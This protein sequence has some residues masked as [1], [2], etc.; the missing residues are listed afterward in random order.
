MASHWNSK[1]AGGTVSRLKTAIILLSIFWLGYAGTAN[2][3]ATTEVGSIPGA[4]DVTLSGS[5][6]YSIPIRIAPGAAGTEPKLAI[7]YDSQSMGSSMGAGWSISGLAAITRG[8]KN[9]FFDGATDGVRL[10]DTDA[11]FLHG[12]RLVAIGATGAGSTR[13]IEYRKDID[14]Q[15]EVVQIGQ[16]LAAANF[17]VRTKG[18]LTMLFGSDDNSKVK[19]RSGPTLLWA[20]SQIV[21]SVG[22]YVQFKYRGSDDGDY[23]IASVHYTG[24]GRID[25]AGKLVS[26]R[27]G[28]AAV[29]FEY[30]AAPRIT[31]S[32]V[33][34]YPVERKSRL[35][36]VRTIV[37]DNP[38]AIQ[39]GPLATPAG[40]QQV[41]RY[42]FDYVDR[43]TTAHRFVLSAVH[44]FGEDDSEITPTKFTYSEPDVGW[45]VADYNLPIGLLFASREQLA[46]AYR[47]V[48][49]SAANLQ[50]PELLFSATID[51]SLESYA[52]KNDGTTWSAA[53]GFK[54]PFP[55]TNADGADLGAVLI[56][57]NGDGR[58]DLLKSHKPRDGQTEASSYLADN[59]SWTQVDG[60]KLPFNVSIEGKRTATMLF[61]R[62]LGN[63]AGPDLIYE[64]EGQLGFLE[65]TGSGWRA[66]A[67]LAPPVP[68]SNF[69]R[70]FDI[71]CD[72]KPELIA[73][74]KDAAGNP[75]WR[76]FRASAAGWTEEVRPAYLPSRFIPASINPQ[77]I[78]ELPLRGSN[79][80]SL[81][82]S[83]GEGGGFSIALRG[84]PSGWQEVGEKKPPFNLV[85]AS[86][87]ASGA[88]AVD[89]DGDGRV[90]VIAH[91]MVPNGPAI[92]FAFRQ[93]ETAWIASSDHEPPAPID[94]AIQ[95]HAFVGDLDGDRRAEI[96]LPGGSGTAL[97]RVWK[98][99]AG[100]FQ[101]IPDYGPRLAFARLD[102]QDRGIRMLDLN[103][104]GLADVVFNRD[105][106]DTQSKG[107]FINTGRG[108]K[109][110]PG[111]TP[112]LPFAGDHITG[113]P[114]QFVDVDGDGFVDLLYHISRTD[115]VVRAYYRNEA[116]KLDA[117]EDE[118]ICG[119]LATRDPRFDRKWVKQENELVPPDG[120]PFT[121]ENVGDR[122]VRFVDLNGDGRPDMLVGYLP[123]RWSFPGGP[124]EVESCRTVEN[125]RTCELN[126][127]PFT[128]AAFLNDGT[129]WIATEEYKPKLPF[130]ARES[131]AYDRSR[132]LFV[133]LVDVDG[134][135]LPDIVA[136]FKHPWDA[137]KDVFETWI[138]TGKGWRLD[139]GFSLPIL[140][141]G[142]RLYL[143]EP[144]RNPRA[145][146][147][148]A[149][150]NGDGLSDIVFTSR[151]G[152]ANES[153]TFFSTGRGFSYAGGSWQIPIQAIS[154]RAGDP[155]YRL[156]DVNGDGFLDVLFSRI[157]PGGNKESGL[158]IN[159]G[160][161]W[162]GVQESLI[163]ALPPFVDEDGRD[164]GVRLFDVDGN[165]MLDVVQ[166]YAR[167]PSGIVP[168]T[169]VL[170]NTGKRSDVLVSIDTGYNLK[171]R[172]FYQSLLETLPGNSDAGFP[173]R[174]P[175]GS[176][177]VPGPL[178]TYPYV[179]PV[180]ATYVVRRAIVEAEQNVA[181]SYR[182]GQFQ[183]HA[184]AL[185]PLGFG[186]RESFN[187]SPDSQIL[188]RTELLQDVNYRNSPSLESV[189]WVP[190]DRLSLPPNVNQ[191]AR[192]SDPVWS[193]FCPSTIPPALSDIKKIS[194]A[195]SEWSL[196]N[197]IVGG[198][199]GLPARSLRQISLVASDTKTFELDGGVVGSQTASFKYDEPVNLVDR[200]QNALE[201]ALKRGD[202]SSV[203]TVN[204]YD[205]DNAAKWFFGRLTKSVVT[206][207]G[208]QIDTNAANRW[209]E[210]R[211]AEF[212]Y[213]VATG[214]LKFELANA[215]VPEKAVRT[216]Y[217]RDVYGNIVT[218]TVTAPYEEP[219]TNETIF[220]DLGRFPVAQVNALGHR[221]QK[222]PRITTGLPS[223]MTGP[224]GLVTRYE[225]SGAG[226][227]TK[228]ISP[229]GIV[230]TSQLLKLEE[231]Q[232]NGGSAGLQV[233]YAMRSV[234]GSL[235][236]ST[237]LFDNKGRV[238]RT[239]SEGFT[240]N[241]A[242]RR[243]IQR[244]IEYDSAGRTTATSLPYQRGNPK[245]WARA[246]FD[247]LG[248][249]KRSLGPDGAIIENR[250][251]SRQ[252]GGLVATL[253]DPLGRTSS[254]ETNMRQLPLKVT[255]ATGSSL[256]LSYDGGDRT[257]M[258]VGP[259]GAVTVHSYDERGQ[260]SESRDPDMGRWRYSYDAFGRLVRQIDAKGE[261]TVVE[262]DLIGRPVR[263][264]QTDAVSWWDYDSAQNGK[265]NIAAVRGSDGYREDFLYDQF[266]RSI[267]SAV[268]IA[269]ETF[270]T[271][272]ELDSF[273]RA[274]RTRFPSGLNVDNIFDE[275]G[276]LTS[277]QNAVSGARY[278]SATDVDEFGRIAEEK[279]GN[280]VTTA[281]SYNS[282]TGRLSRISSTSD[283]QQPLLDLQL[284]YDLVGNLTQREESSGIR[285]PGQRIME[286]FEYDSLDRLTG[287]V[288]S[289]GARDRY[290]FDVAGRITF[291][292]GVGDYSYNTPV[293]AALPG[294]NVQAKPF[295]SVLRTRST[296]T[297]TTYGYDSNGNMVRGPAGTFEY[298]A[299]NRLKFA[300]AD[301]AR[302]LRFDYA[303]NGAR[304]KQFDRTGIDAI[305]TLYIGS[306]ERVAQFQGPLT[307]ARRG[308]VYRHRHHL[309]N[310]TGVFATVE[311][312]GEY[313]DVLIGGPSNRA[314]A[315]V[316]R[317]LIEVTKVWY[318]LADQLGSV[319]RVVDER[320]QI[321]ASYWYDPWGKRTIS[322]RTLPGLRPGLQLGATWTRGFTWHEHVDKF[323]LIHMNG[324]VY[325][326]TT[327]LFTSPDPVGAGFGNTQNAG[328]FKYA[329]GN[330]LKY[331]DPS[332]YFDIGGF[333]GGVV[334]WAVGGPIGA[335][336]GLFAAGDESTRQFV[337]ENW[338][339]AVIITAVVVVT[340]ATGGGGA[341]LG[342]AIL[343]GM[344]AG[345]TAGGLTAA[346]YGG[347]FDDIVEATIKGA[348]LGAVS[349]AVGYGIAS[350][351]LQGFSHYVAQGVSSGATQT[352][353]GGNFGRGF[354]VGFAT[355]AIA[356]GSSRF[357]VS[358]SSF[359]YKVAVGAITGGVASQLSGGKFQ[360][361]AVAG[362]F[363]AA[364]TQ[365]GRE[366]MAT[367]GRPMTRKEMELTKRW[368][369]E[370]I[371]MSR[372]RIVDGQWNRFQDP[373]R[374]MAPNGNIYMGS[375]FCSDYAG[376]CA[377][378]KT[379]TFIHEMTHV[380]QYQ[381]DQ[382]FLINAGMLQLSASF[383]RDIYNYSSGNFNA[384]QY[385]QQG[386]Y[387]EDAYMWN[388]GRPWK[389][390]WQ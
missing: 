107:A 260:R 278:W 290:A 160:S 323:S 12:Q 327:S 185:R 209:Q 234:T 138:N 24:R 150:I 190:F 21:D 368:F 199:D 14:D 35:V 48:R 33:G 127:A 123:L 186:W 10:E 75:G 195:R 36:S 210:T 247:Q 31:Q 193:N 89:V 16:D 382:G 55:F 346:L 102:R 261:T 357:D 238:V 11:L 47:F 183:V 95:T 339:T 312:S 307:D 384:L 60:Y 249:I 383:G 38:A 359:A 299:D 114:V 389:Y 229:T 218:S 246:E 239:I 224:T 356:N 242:L 196:R 351:G 148:W 230:S 134:D 155:T 8:P 64:S 378:W 46:G 362:A 215:H 94:G 354:A 90:D 304:Y 30:E 100:A 72:G 211:V 256:R 296:D 315:A 96:V 87:Q 83:S 243:P 324:R 225:Y 118:A 347:S 41:A 2:A 23:D 214:L 325:D 226:R 321:A 216:K 116:C 192:P 303:P 197:Q 313:S 39:S 335:G 29:L 80:S 370:K 266:G 282:D 379:A 308:R 264:V 169:T 170:V 106:S 40:W 6:T 147:Q 340:V 56:D 117:S 252:E 103:G 122:G 301:Q 326:Q 375:T 268:T 110:A 374:A 385:E 334:G 353:Q 141:T 124:P 161:G 20:V 104:D 58:T 71:D 42:A 77:A 292:S 202:G 26:E 387:N 337:Q 220:D 159:S 140:P 276:F 17:V 146:A 227:V 367:D 76:I 332:G 206:K 358:R 254:T 380:M 128:V 212:G 388:D 233:A 105:A 285:G 162:V 222:V 203:V 263:R 43:P 59:N 109:T 365:I 111:L 73:I 68:I 133:Q 205:E 265:G 277:V 79:C 255:D 317:S 390:P 349:G 272:A 373:R 53:A 166:S 274:T 322:Q 188:T 328:R 258:M 179:A 49:F 287:F 81:I 306:Y 143:D 348:V 142:A 174:V 364:I 267:G 112:P 15:T 98:G 57:L 151:S 204:T 191:Y 44:Q 369:G 253:V 251:A 163:A 217:V 18:G 63:S 295:H 305:E 156:L 342:A 101:E 259:N 298:T 286:R 228:E 280:G 371:D 316:P 45:K 176:V 270:T 250:Y 288:K 289:D 189:C 139:Q 126:R 135:R 198:V 52:F 74:V 182:Y 221:V 231:L 376:E 25:D 284:S 207:T 99:T 320:G 223:A 302:W 168:E 279:F 344:A 248:R 65:N 86:G 271:L 19:V 120:F 67:A 1:C 235:P 165:G 236:P 154:E 331:Q 153:A 350:A 27:G 22:N 361:G 9:V 13:R 85:T 121:E 232:D 167:G 341:T 137:S 136:G 245:R 130:V 3:Q 314:A 178:P 181:F 149:D 152:P 381:A 273:G 88:L 200:R 333:I 145:L 119:V 172:I 363:A 84:S 91:K 275:K 310:G 283:T 208:D 32:F 34:G 194:E 113:N 144:R 177:Y 352:I 171:T 360:N 244:D 291:K 372:V 338:R 241:P 386:Q 108:W 366:A 281:R 157:V 62:I 240:A 336:I 28:F 173:A 311:I 201:V 319:I 7:T 300:F 92:R 269:G 175:W 61:G 158:F 294:E 131:S 329:L 69:A 345:A 180:P 51:G 318:L 78:L 66:N 377:T 115:G 70:L 97:G 262:Y 219:R 187:E 257:R 82:A 50:L 93:T 297:E 309:S 184:S 129:R 37:T 293:T 237:K 343:S 213:D 330:P 54:P 125:V 355:G 5:S 132:D 4:F 164:Q